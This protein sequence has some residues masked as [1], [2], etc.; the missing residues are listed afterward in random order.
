MTP[1]QA[2]LQVIIEAGRLFVSSP[3]VAS[4]TQRLID[5]SAQ[6][7]TDWRIYLLMILLLCCVLWIMTR[8][9]AS[10][11]KQTKFLAD[12]EA[13]VQAHFQSCTKVQ[14]S[15]IADYAQTKITVS[16]LMILM[17]R[18]FKGKYGRYLFDTTQKAEDE[19]DGKS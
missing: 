15:E 14:R 5:S 4:V 2:I 10:E 11:E 13:K 18:E 17:D 19:P 3:K 16:K 1:E 9:R 6:S 7:G 12:L 8:L